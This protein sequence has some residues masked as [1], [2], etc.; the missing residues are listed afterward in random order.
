MKIADYSTLFALGGSWRQKRAEKRLTYTDKSM[1]TRQAMMVN[2]I[3]PLWGSYNPKRLTVDVIDSAMAGVKSKFKKIKNADEKAPVEYVPLGSASRNRI[4]SVLSE[5]YMHLMLIKVVKYNPVRDVVRCR[6]EPDHPRA[7][8]SVKDMGKLFPKTHEELKALYVSQRYICAFMILKDTGLRP[9]ELVALKW[10]DWYPEEKFFPILKAIESG[11]R[12]KEKGTKTGATKPAIITDQTA[13]EIEA[14][15]KKVKPKPGEYIFANC[16]GIPY[17]THRLSYAFHRAVDRSGINR[18]EL[19]PYNLRHTF[20]TVMLES[21]PDKM[22]D[23][24][25]GHNTERMK[26][27]YRHAGLESLKR[28]AANIRAEVNAARLF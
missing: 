6:Q 10:E 20:V 24:L 25:S 15:R 13:M 9:G 8:L 28:E 2:Y 7:A 21:L 1:R 27:F 11:T 4:L 26:K 18:P 14:L 22:M 17:D 19:V 5:L 16:Y 12:G 3:I 23:S